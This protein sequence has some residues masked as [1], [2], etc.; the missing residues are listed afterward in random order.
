MKN[1]RWW[2]SLWIL[3]PLALGGCVSGVGR[4]EL[5]EEYFNLGNAFFELGDFDRSYRYY[6]QAIALTDTFPAAGYNLVRLLID[7]GD[8]QR[9]DELLGDLRR[10]DPE[11]L[12]LM[13]TEAYLRVR[14]DD[15][16]A[17]SVLYRQVLQES[18]GRVRVAYNL[19]LL[20]WMQG[21]YGEAR[22]VLVENRLFVENDDEYLWLLADVL[23]R[24]D[25]EEAALI[26]L[27]RY[28]LLVRDDA[29]KV[30]RLLQRYVEWGFYL[31][32]LEAAEQPPA[33]LLRDHD[34]HFVRAVAHLRGGSDF[35]TGQAAFAQA[36]EQGF[37]DVAR[38]DELLQHLPSDEAEVLR[39]L[40]PTDP[41]QD[42][43][44][45][46]EGP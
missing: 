38:I 41:A 21:N 27:D 40:V 12:L 10:E 3:I 29:P 17:A 24:N 37:S 19:G 13:E 46:S 35:S 15:H 8:L 26:D 14:R 5:A 31:A 36:I 11:S 45:D 4:Q 2:V 9:A 7:R 22:D 43:L 33:A 23:Y 42:P 32:A 16:E 30:L 44:T 39:E 18:P 25:Q 1:V 6:S 28:F 20:E 34:Y